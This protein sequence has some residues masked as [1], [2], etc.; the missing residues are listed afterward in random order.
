VIERSLREAVR[1]VSMTGLIDPSGREAAEDEA[2]PLVRDRIEPGEVADDVIVVLDSPE[3]AC[4]WLM[5][6]QGI[7]ERDAVVSTSSYFAN[8]LDAARAGRATIYPVEAFFSD[9]AAAL[10]KL[11]GDLGLPME[12]QCFTPVCQD[13]A[14]QIRAASDVS[15]TLAAT[16]VA[17]QALSLFRTRAPREAAR[18]WWDRSLFLWGDRPGQPCPQWLDV[19]GP[20]R[21]LIYGP[22]IS[23]P[24]GDWSAR[25]EL[26]LSPD[27]ARR[28]Y[29]LEFGGAAGFSQVPFGPLPPGSYAV[30]VAHRF[31]VAAYSELRLWV[32]R[33][34]F[35]GDLS[36]K[37]AVIEASPTARPTV[38][39]ALIR[40][41]SE[42]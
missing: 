1:E 27:A 30:S 19:T 16:P 28:S 35:H 32:V 36:L 23:L 42:S 34:A 13:F 38:S 31:E 15:R 20:R 10:R 17:T 25:M 40:R 3:R 39:D 14:P 26:E 9:P 5:E 2:V 22:Y 29:V 12:P 8:A 41:T 18:A 37:G 4:A 11:V 33:A 21:P 24:A 6:S 7:N